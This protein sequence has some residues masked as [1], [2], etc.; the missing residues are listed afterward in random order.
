MQPSRLAAASPATDSGV[1]VQLWSVALPCKQARVRASEIRRITG[2]ELSGCSSYSYQSYHLNQDCIDPESSVPM[3]S[4]K[5]RFLASPPC[6]LQLSSS[7]W[8][9]WHRS[10][11]RQAPGQSRRSQGHWCRGLRTAA[12]RCMLQYVAI[13][14][15]AFYNKKQLAG[16]QT[17]LRAGQHAS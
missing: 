4:L 5:G 3:R 7:G 11:P 1:P 9:S 14:D 2:S 8:Q 15:F 17:V 10:G 13:C 12:L 16:E 6:A